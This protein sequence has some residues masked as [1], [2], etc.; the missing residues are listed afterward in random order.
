MIKPLVYGVIYKK[1]FFR[2]NNNTNAEIPDGAGPD[3]E[4]AQGW[5]DA[6]VEPDDRIAIVT[7]TLNP[8]DYWRGWFYFN[9]M[10]DEDEADSVEVN[11]QDHLDIHWETNNSGG[12]YDCTKYEHIV[13]GNIIETINH[14][15]QESECN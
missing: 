3:I 15:E 7:H 13:N 5:Y 11:S 4:S 1:G 10:S 2:F 9:D 6:V 8:N 12:H 14:N